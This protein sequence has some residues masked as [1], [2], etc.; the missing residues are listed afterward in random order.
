MKFP[1]LW[2]KTRTCIS[3]F[4]KGGLG[5]IFEVTGRKIED[6]IS[7]C[8]QSGPPSDLWDTAPL[9]RYA[10][11]DDLIH[12]KARYPDYCSNGRDSRIAYDWGLKPMGRLF[13]VDKILR[14]QPQRIL[15]VGTGWDT[16]FAERFGK[17]AEYWGIDDGS[18]DPLGQFEESLVTRPN[19]QFVRG[20]LGDFNSELP[21][22]YFDM[23]ISVSVLEH[24]PSEN[25]RRVYADAFRVLRPGGCI[26]SS[27]D[28]PTRK[29]AKWDLK[30][31]REA[32]FIMPSRPDLMIRTNSRQG[33]ATL[34]EPLDV[35]FLAYFG[36]NRE[37]VWT[38]LHNVSCHHP[39]VLTIGF[40]PGD[41]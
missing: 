40:K 1:N 35:V 37:N 41:D 39:T 29:S 17:K 30:C 18:F 20:Y 27:I 5:G 12:L 7:P 13:C 6:L 15:E 31:M 4:R 33:R 14:L 25:T 22:S 19:A 34:F 28:C 38:D 10:T 3:I 16:F 36:M 21:D 26:V 23:L 2:K 24:V 32:G 8:L 11:C 9:F